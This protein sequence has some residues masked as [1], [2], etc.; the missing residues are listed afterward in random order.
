MPKRYDREAVFAS[1]RVQRKKLHTRM[2][3]PELLIKKPMIFC[4]V[5]TL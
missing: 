1:Q 3:N 2:A 4:N 5:M